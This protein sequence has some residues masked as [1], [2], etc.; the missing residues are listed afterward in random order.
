MRNNSQNEEK[1]MSTEYK[2][3]IKRTEQLGQLKEV[4]KYILLAL[5]DPVTLANMSGVNRFFKKIIDECDSLWKIHVIREISD[6]PQLEIVDRK[7]PQKTRRRTYKE[8]Y[9]AFYEFYRRIQSLKGK[10]AKAIKEKGPESIEAKSLT[11]DA[12]HQFKGFVIYGYDKLCE[13]FPEFEPKEKII[14]RRETIAWAKVNYLMKTSFLHVAAMSGSV[15]FVKRFIGQKIPVD[16]VECL[17]NRAPILLRL[18]PPTLSPDRSFY[19]D[20]YTPLGIAI[21]YGKI[22]SVQALIEAKA[23][24]NHINPVNGHTP[25]HLA[26]LK[27]DS[28]CTALLLK[29]GARTDMLD[30]FNRRPYDVAKNNCQEL[31]ATKMRERGEIIETASSYS[32]LLM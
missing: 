2:L 9:A 27:G 16:Q 12:Y 14:D 11:E 29:A 28:D 7:N 13:H 8:I 3:C 30:M 32:C 10:L 24:V 23:N 22:V 17:I 18:C 4:V 19:K 21:R 26:A 6:N 25:L 1:T 31:I 15:Y 5:M 20:G